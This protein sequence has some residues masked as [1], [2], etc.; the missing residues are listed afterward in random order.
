MYY[1]QIKQLNENQPII[2]ISQQQQQQQS[3]NNNTTN[4]NL[5]IKIQ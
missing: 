4:L 2:K 3:N 1:Q 5:L